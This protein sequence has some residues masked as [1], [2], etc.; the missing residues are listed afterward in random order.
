MSEYVSEDG[1][2]DMIFR[3]QNIHKV[4]VPKYSIEKLFWVY[5]IYL[6]AYNKLSNSFLFAEYDI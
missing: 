6:E 3:L 1:S 4:Q 5:S 2:Q